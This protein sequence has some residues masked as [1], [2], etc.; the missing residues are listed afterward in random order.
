VKRV[1][2]C[3]ITGVGKTTFARAL[4]KQTG[5]SYHEMDALYHGP[6]WQPIATFEED[7]ARIVAEPQWVFDSHGYSQ[8]RDLMWSRADTVVWLDL[9]RAVVMRRV[10]QRSTRRAI[11]GEPIF[12]DNI[13]TFWAW[14][15]SEHPVQWAWTQYQPRRDDMRQRFADPR[16]AHVRR[17]RITDPRS[18]ERWLRCALP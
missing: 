16:Y 15:D 4:A 7:V 10:L 14:L 17:V 5:L 9:S 3:G 6:N 12:N 8:V 18:A 13:E 11:S 2:V 1:L